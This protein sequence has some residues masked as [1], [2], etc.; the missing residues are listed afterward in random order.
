GIFRLSHERQE[1]IEVWLRR[2]QFWAV[3]LL[4]LVPGFRVILTLVCGVSRVDF[5]LFVPSVAISATIWACIFVGLG[6]ALG[7]EY[8][9][10]VEAIEENVS[11]GVSLAVVAG[12]VLLAFAI[13]R[14]RRRIFRRRESAR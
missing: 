2:Y 14:L 5:R 9:L 12:V 10:L 4:R 6:W 11:I 1:R 3:I 13:F 7:D 8:E